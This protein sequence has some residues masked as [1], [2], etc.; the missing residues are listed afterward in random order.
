MPEILNFSNVPLN[1]CVKVISF[2]S[3]KQIKKKSYWNETIL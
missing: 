3:D 1:F 2:N